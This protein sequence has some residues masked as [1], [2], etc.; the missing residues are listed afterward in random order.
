MK[1]ITWDDLC[2]ERELKAIRTDVRHPFESEAGGCALD[3]GGVVVFAF[4]DP[5]D[6]YRSCCTSI[7]VARGSLYE[8]GCDP[9]YIRSPVVITRWLRDEYGREC[10]GIELVDAKSGK[11]VLRLGTQYVKEHYPSYTCEWMPQNLASNATAA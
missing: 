4:E 2:G 1:P 11:V 5:S 3:L 6:G 9:E 10:D 8:F 7:L